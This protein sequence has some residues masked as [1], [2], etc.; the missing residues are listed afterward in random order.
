MGTLKGYKGFNR[1]L[2][3]TPNNKVFQ[4]EIGKE[5]EEPEANLC[6]SGFHFCEFP[7]DVF[8][9]YAPADSRYCEVGAE[10]VSEETGNGDSKRAAKKIRIGA[11]IG[12]KGIIEASVKFI[13]DKVDWD[14]AKESNTGH[15]S[16]ATNTG[17]QSAATNTGA[18]S[19]ATNTGAQ[20]AAT[21]E[22]KE[23]VAISLGIKGCAKGTIGCWIV[24][25]EWKEI[26]NERHRTDVKSALV[27][28][29]VIKADTYYMLVDGEFVEAEG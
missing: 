20:S 2:Q 4:Y 15:R 14:N 22:G 7:M 3:C 18:Q 25:A 1:K 26:G 12:L 24:L 5:Y 17:D 19:A 9:H 6:N 10:E 13:F 8:G 16:A 11:E 28:G 23:S 29:E 21:V 27:D